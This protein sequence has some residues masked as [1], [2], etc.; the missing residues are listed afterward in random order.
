MDT[1]PW[2]YEKT[3]VLLQDFDRDVALKDIKLQW[4]SFWIQIFNLPLKSRTRETDWMIGNKLGEVL[5]VDV[6]DKGDPPSANKEKAPHQYRPWLRGEPFKHPPNK[7]VPKFFSQPP[8][9]ENHRSAKEG[10]KPS[11]E[12]RMVGV[13]YVTKQ[14]SD[15]TRPFATTLTHLEESHVPADLKPG[16]KLATG[17]TKGTV[18]KTEQKHGCTRPESGYSSDKKKLNALG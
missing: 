17:P 5:D 3:L 1:C 16:T 10:A 14:A 4:C 13:P 18:T 12:T 11:Y 2:S 8:E 15:P 9:S 7:D 6:P